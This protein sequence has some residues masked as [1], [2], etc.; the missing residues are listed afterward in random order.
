MQTRIEGDPGKRGVVV[1]E[2]EKV[3]FTRKAAR[4]PAATGNLNLFLT[5]MTRV[6]SAK[7]QPS[8]KPKPKPKQGKERGELC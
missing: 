7:L 6:V 8:S 1:K 5:R 3:L 2:R 4:S